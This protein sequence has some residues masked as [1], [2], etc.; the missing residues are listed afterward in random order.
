MT[1]GLTPQQAKLVSEG[2][3]SVWKI[4]RPWVR[5]RLTRRLQNNRGS[6]SRQISKIGIESASL[7]EACRMWWMLPVVYGFVTLGFS[8]L[9]LISGRSFNAGSWV[10]FT[11]LFI[12]GFIRWRSAM[13]AVK[14]RE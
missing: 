12:P 10:V 9:T 8:G 4:E 1:N 14:N 5:R 3:V 7:L 11:L 13:R 6:L 2:C